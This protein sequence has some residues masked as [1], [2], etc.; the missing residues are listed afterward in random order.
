MQEFIEKYENT[1][2][3]KIAISVFIILIAIIIYKIVLHLFAKSEKLYKD[4]DEIKKKRATYFRLFRSILRYVVIIIT[5]LALLEVNGVKVTSLFAG[6]GILSVIVGLAIQDWLKDIIRGSSLVSDNYFQVGDVIKYND[7]EA[8]VLVIGIKTTK[9]QDIKTSNI[10]CIA[11]RRLEEVQVVS[12]KNYIEIPMPYELPLKRAEAIVNDIIEEVK[13]NDKVKDCI[14]KSVNK[15]D[16]SSI[17]YYIEVDC[18]PI[19]KLQ[20]K[21]DTLR[22]ILSVMENNSISVPY[23]Q[24]DIHNK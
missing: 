20:V 8:K 24:I 16:S 12:E 21:R 3:F 1:I 18:K 4:G 7:I 13:K 17:N 23:T 6:L 9:I 11:N 15:L 22:T 19:D 5:A 10:I 14:Y 2:Y